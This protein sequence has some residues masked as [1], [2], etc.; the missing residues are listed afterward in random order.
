M[1]APFKVQVKASEGHTKEEDV[2]AASIKGAKTIFTPGPNLK[3]MLSSLKY[4]KAEK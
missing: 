2:S 3:E 1:L 4:T